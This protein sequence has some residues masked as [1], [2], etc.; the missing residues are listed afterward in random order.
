[1][2]KDAIGHLMAIKSTLVA[3]RR[4][5]AAAAFQR[6]SNKMTVDTLSEAVNTIVALQAKIDIVDRALREE[7]SLDG[8]EATAKK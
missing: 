6:L 4:R 3:D 1:M 5:V 8:V 2:A 7:T